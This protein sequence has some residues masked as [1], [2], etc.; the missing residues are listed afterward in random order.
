[1]ERSPLS[2]MLVEDA[3]PAIETGD[4]VD[5]AYPICN[6]DRTIGATLS[7]EVTNQRGAAGLPEGTIHVR[8]AGTAGQSLG[9]WL[10]PGITLR[11]QGTANDYVGKGMGGGRIVIVPRRAAVGQSA[12]GAGNAVLY[13]AT[14]GHVFIAGRVGQRFAV[15]NSGA[16]AVVE[17]ASDHGCEYMT[18]GLVVVLG[19]VGRN[20]AAGMTGGTA[21]VWDPQQI[22]NRFVADTA[23]AVRRLVEVEA[24]E[25][26]ALVEEHFRETESSTA[27]DILAR[28][29]H[30]VD[31]F[32]VLHAGGPEPEPLEALQEMVGRT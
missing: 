27:Q 15:R 1:M 5:L 29:D 8:L 31:R 7:G 25:L 19:R 10:A 30:Q 16:V 20:F 14:G 23:P 32:W 9:A 21:Y 18:G 17:G 24:L 11:L 13:G 28:W 6:A 22:L 12:Q 3:R 2:S 4:P 26:H